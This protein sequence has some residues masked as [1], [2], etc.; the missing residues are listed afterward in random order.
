MK[1]LQPACESLNHS[2]K[3]AKTESFETSY[4]DH[5]FTA[6]SKAGTTSPNNKIKRLNLMQAQ[7]SPCQQSNLS[8]IL[9]GLSS[10]LG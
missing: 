5:I 4:I 6:I 10:C 9:S 7:E 2:I 1:T 8:N 3:N